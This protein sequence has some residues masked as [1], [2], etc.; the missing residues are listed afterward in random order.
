MKLN[1]RPDTLPPGKYPMAVNVRSY[2]GSSVRTRPGLTQ[3]GFVTG[4]SNKWA[5]DM[6]AYVQLLSDNKP[7]L[8]TRNADDTIWLPDNASQV[9]VLAGGG[10]SL[11]AS[12]IPFRPNQSPNP[13][14]YI[15][16][17]SDYQKFSAPATASVVTQQKVG[18]AEPQSAPDAVIDNYLAVGQF[19][20]AVS[21]IAGGTTAASANGVRVAD[22]AGVVIVDPTPGSTTCSIQV[23]NT[24]GYQRG[25]FL[26]INNVTQ[27]LVQDVF[28][29]FAA[30]FAISSLY[31]FSG[32]AGH[33]V[34]VPAGLGSGPG[35]ADSS[36][37]L[38]NFLSSVR[39]GALIKIGTEV[40]LVWS[41]A[42]GPDGTVAIETSTVN[43]H[44]AAD[45][46]TSVPAIQVRGNGAAPTIPVVGQS[47]SSLDVT[48]AVT[49]GIGTQTAT[50]AANPFLFGGSVLQFDDYISIGIRTDVPTNLT[51]MKFLI[52][53]DDGTF[54]KNFYYYTVR[55]SDLASAIANA[56][57]QIAAAQTVAQRAIVD[58]ENAIA[59]GNQGVT[60]SGAQDV[61]GANQW[62]QIVFSINEMTRV[63]ND[64]TKS[65]QTATKI[66]FLWNANGSLNVAHDQ[67]FLAFGT[68]QP[69]V[70][71]VGAP[72]LYRVRPRSSV[73]GVR[74]NPSPPTRYGVNPRR[75][76]VRVSLP[77]AAYDPQI[78]TW[79]IERYGGTVT[80]WRFVGS[81]PTTLSTFIDNFSDEA[82]GAGE[83]L[84]FD[85]F[86]PW[87]SIDLPLVAVANSVT[88]TT[89]LV[90]IAA[91]IAAHVLNFLPGNLVKIGGQNVYT[92]YKRPVLISGTTYRFEFVENAGSA[93][94]PVLINIYEPEFANQSLPY[95][96]GPDVSG[97]V[98][99]VGDPLRPGTL[100]FAKPNNPDSAPDSFNIEIT[101]PSEPLL[102]G[103]VMDGLSF[104]GSTERW[105]ALY[106]QPDN[107]TQRYNFVQQPFPRGI[108]APFGHCNDGQSLYWWAKDGIQSSSK[109]SLTDDD[110]YNLF[111]HE[112]V[113][114]QQVTYNGTIVQAPDYT[115]APTFRLSYSNGYLYATYQDLG[116]TFRQL[117]LNLR[118]MAWVAD[119][120]PTQ[121]SN[122][123]HVEQ[124]AES[125]AVLNPVT[126][127]A[128][129]AAIG[130][131][132]GAIFKQSDL[133]N[134]GTTPIACTLAVR[135]F[136]GG[137]ARAP[138]QWGDFFLDLLPAAVA[139]V[140]ATPMS[141]GA[142]VV[143]PTTI[144][145]GAARARL[146]VSM[147][148]SP[149][150]SDFMGLMLQWTDDFT[151][152][153]KPTQ[154]FLWQPS[155]DIQPART[156][157]WLTFGTSFGLKGFM[158]IPQISIAWVST[159]PITLTITTVDGQS[160][161][162]ITIPSSG[163][164]YQKALFRVSANKGQLYVFAASSSA[165]FQIFEDDIEILVGQWGRDGDYL[166]AK[167]F[168]GSASAQSPI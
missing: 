127:V 147:G 55:A 109:G 101:P 73:T 4:V 85:N 146:P 34:L 74:G 1:S 17:G 59:S 28:P 89:A 165:P 62:A 131:T 38:Q 54:T 129:R 126:L 156:I 168:G 2:T 142:Q 8:L 130:G 139:G 121:V 29:P 49:A 83:E 63:G 93:V 140:V 44:V 97:T 71:A 164:V 61:T 22:T 42:T 128:G 123:Y 135:E 94:G 16:N 148:G 40:C 67:A 76:Q 92:L 69:D 118:T 15:A 52:D 157:G 72:Y 86:E 112:G 66:Q 155:Y 145:T 138:K 100:Y 137:D 11:G 116:G 48:Y 30:A 32:T 41:V 143:A 18:I 24:A 47:I 167:S 46:I 133:T 119:V 99:A 161:Q 151:T 64:Q 114:G 98:F 154:L 144:P 78:D 136:D 26:I 150:V 105:W 5:T 27:F 122:I 13:W 162:V 68:G 45:G 35:N 9:G 108:A 153:T 70:G 77:S 31:Y 6:R 82:V 20:A 106:P 84:D 166:I 21:W 75:Q 159:A 23:A 134:D 113:V 57:S 163:G 65:L 50:L 88:G 81:I 33:C 19:T 36:I 58:E 25:M 56:I 158:H 43:A 125:S 10:A 80:S 111:P 132:Q 96:W 117:T 107:P 115:R 152:Q 12:M 160:P 104:V 120:Y 3:Y 102:G 51:E 124:Q 37:Y 95:M 141:L 103:E 60:Y 53:V 110:L 149:V 90:V 14:M 87:P 39:R 79:D 7:R 91:P